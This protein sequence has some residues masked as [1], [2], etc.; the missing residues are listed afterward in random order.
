[1]FVGYTTEWAPSSEGT[2]EG[3][4]SLRASCPL[5]RLSQPAGLIDERY[6]ALDQIVYNKARE[7]GK[8]EELYGHEAVQYIIEQ[9]LGP[10]ALR[11]YDYPAGW[12]GLMRYK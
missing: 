5:T 6:Q 4:A 1:M 2:G 11:H 8:P 7:S 10:T 3:R 9:T 12:H